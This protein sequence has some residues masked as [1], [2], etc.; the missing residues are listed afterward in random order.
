MPNSDDPY[1]PPP[2][3]DHADDHGGASSL[4]SWLIEPL[5]ADPIARF[6]CVMLLAGGLILAVL[7]LASMV[8]FLAIRFW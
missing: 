5:A 7:G 6:G 8:W 2:T 3:E 4:L 1:Q